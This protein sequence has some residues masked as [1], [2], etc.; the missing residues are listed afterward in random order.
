M[1]FRSFLLTTVKAKKT[2]KFWLWFDGVS[3]GNI[4]GAEVL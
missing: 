1:H 4:R 2:Q 3:P